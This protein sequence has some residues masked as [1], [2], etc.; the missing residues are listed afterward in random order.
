MAEPLT[1]ILGA[2][3]AAEPDLDRQ[4]AEQTVTQALCC[5]VKTV[6]PFL[7]GL[8]DVLLH[9]EGQVAVQA[10]DPGDLVPHAG[11][12]GGVAVA[13]LFEALLHPVAEPVDR[14]PAHRELLHGRDGLPR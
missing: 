13:L 5:P 2:V 14:P 4:V 1:V 3:T 12:D 9:L 10:I 8:H 6:P 11:F 7:L